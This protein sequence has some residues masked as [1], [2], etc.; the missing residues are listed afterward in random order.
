[1]QFGT[2]SVPTPAQTDSWLNISEW[3]QQDLVPVQNITEYRYIDSVTYSNIVNNTLY[4]TSSVAPDYLKVSHPY[5][6]TIDSNI[7]PFIVIQVTSDNGYG[8]SYTSKK[9]YEIRGLNDLY[10]GVQNIES[11]GPFVP[12][13]PVTTPL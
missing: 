3:V 12:I 9:N 8:V 2:V 10:T 11:I 1:V 7:D 13:S 5:N 4:Y 6:F